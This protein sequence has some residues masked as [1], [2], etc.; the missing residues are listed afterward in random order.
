VLEQFLR[1]LFWPGKPALAAVAVG[2]IALTGV[3]PSSAQAK[4]SPHAGN[5]GRFIK[6]AF[7]PSYLAIKFGWLPKGASV[8]GGTTQ[9]AFEQIY[10]YASFSAQWALNAY[11]KGVCHPLT[12][13]QQFEC[14]QLV[15]PLQ[16]TVPITG[17]GPVIDGHRSWW[18]QGGQP[19]LAFEYAP[20]AWAQAQSLGT[21]GGEA[22]V[23][24]IARRAEFGRHLPFRFAN[25][26]TSLPSGWQIIATDF[27]TGSGEYLPDAY[28]ILK[29]RT[30]SPATP[31]TMGNDVAPEVPWIGVIPRLKGSHGCQHAKSGYVT[32]NG[33]RYLLS[34]S[35]VTKH[36]YSQTVTCG[37]VDGLDVFVSEIGPGAHPRFVLSA[38]QIVQRMKLLG[39]RQSNWVTNPIP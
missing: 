27:G 2:A 13:D 5:Y 29:L 23:V 21:T 15:D 20:G 24:R 14:S 22:T 9:P 36:R 7:N 10:G 6:G 8:N 3:L 19:D 37:D 28:K 30:I 38:I 33:D 4:T 1:K 16:P 25:R 35:K 39:P 18:I 26:F 32:I 34:Y 31:V 17:R 11:A 12:G